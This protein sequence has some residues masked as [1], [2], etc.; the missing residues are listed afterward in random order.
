MARSNRNRKP[1][2]SSRMS[3]PKTQNRAQSKAQNARPSNQTIPGSPSSSD[4]VEVV[5]SDGPAFSPD[6]IDRPPAYRLQPQ[7]REGAMV[8]SYEG[9]FAQTYRIAPFNPDAFISSKGYDELD[10]LWN[11]AAYA[12]PFRVLLSALLYKGWHIRPAIQ[13]QTDPEFETAQEIAEMLD[14]HL[15]NIIDEADNCQDFRQVLKDIARPAIHYGFSATEIEY[16]YVERGKGRGQWGFKRFSVKEP[17][18]IGFLLDPVN[19]AVRA[20]IPY[21]ASA[22]GAQEPIPPEKVVIH[23]FQPERGLPYGRG[24]AR[25]CYKHWWALDTL[26]KIHAISLEVHGAPNYKVTGPAANKAKAKAILDEVQKARA[27]GVVFV[28]EGYVLDLLQLA[29]GAL[30]TFVSAKTWHTEQIAYAVLL[31][32]LT[33]STGKGVG[34][35]ALGEIHQHTQEYGLEDERKAL[36]GMALN[37]I[38]RRWT[39]Y[40]YGDDAEHLA[41][42]LDLGE[43]D[44]AEKKVIADF[45]ATLI[46]SGVVHPQEPQIRERVNIEPITPEARSLMEQK[47]K[48]DLEATQVTIQERQKA[49]PE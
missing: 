14:W 24:L 33:T 15:R 20:I 27:S 38:S 6:T 48:L 42:R 41:P 32:Q 1:G 44:A 2:K 7:D 19:L 40:N 22:Y 47:E 3:A 17:K 13:D 29:P 35:Y 34:A 10:K 30:E 16:R 39:R 49:P 21:S 46:D 11:S 23:T 28:P 26:E 31:Q 45:Y 18:Q 4:D 5:Y 25:V 8:L 36:E 12:A 9:A 43:W 37:D